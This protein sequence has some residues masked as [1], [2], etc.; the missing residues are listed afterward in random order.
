[1]DLKAPRETKEMPDS[2]VG[3]HWTIS[4]FI[5]LFCALQDCLDWKVQEDTLGRLEPKAKWG[6]RET[7]DCLSRELLAKMALLVCKIV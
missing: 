2:Q 7:L 1:M 5:G 4:I 6:P 3:R